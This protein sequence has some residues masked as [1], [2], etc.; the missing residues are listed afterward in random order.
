VVALAAAASALDPGAIRVTVPRRAVSAA[1]VEKALAATEKPYLLA[2]VDRPA[3][4]GR[5]VLADV[6]LADDAGFAWRRDR[7]LVDLVADQ[8]EP[9]ATVSRALDEAGTV[10]GATCA[11]SFVAD[12][13]F[14]A[15]LAPEF[16]AGLGR[17]ARCDATV[18]VTRVL[19]KRPDARPRA[20]KLALV[21]AAL[22]KRTDDAAADAAIRAAVGADDW[23][24]R[25]AEVAAVE[26]VEPAAVPALLR[27]RA[28]ITWVDAA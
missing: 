12:L 8:A 17:G 4:L 11:W 6:A 23:D 20:E 15:A 25:V 13:A 18:A 16:A 22:R 28:A 19:E 2:P 7:Y 26:G 24:A 21:A 3:A 5:C 27:A 10:A 14:R 1:D 9:W